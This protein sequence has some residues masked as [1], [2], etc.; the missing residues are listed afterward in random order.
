MMLL[1]CFRAYRIGKYSNFIA[2]LFIHR[3]STGKSYLQGTLRSHPD[4]KPKRATKGRGSKI[5]DNFQ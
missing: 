3:R 5:V 2:R 4:K 1:K